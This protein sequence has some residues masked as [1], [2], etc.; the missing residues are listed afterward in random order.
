[1]RSRQNV[2]VDGSLRDGAWFATVFTDI[3]TRF[4][5]YKIAIFV[6][7]APEAVVRQRVKQRAAA[8]G[9]TVAEATLVSSLRSVASSLEVL[10]P[11]CDFVARISNERCPELKAYE[12]VDHSGNWAVIKAQFAAQFP[13]PG[14]F[15]E[16]LAPLS[17]RSVNLSHT[18]A[19]PLLRVK[20]PRLLSAW[21]HARLL[22]AD[23][24]PAALVEASKGRRG[25]SHLE[26]LTTA[27]AS[28][29]LVLSPAHPV[30][31]DPVSRDAAGIPP[32][33]VSFVFCYP[34]V[35]VDW[36]VVRASRI[37]VS[38]PIARVLVAG[39][40]VYFDRAGSI[41][42]V[43]AVMDIGYTDEEEGEE[44]GGGGGEGGVGEGGVDE[45]VGAEGHT[46]EHKGVESKSAAAAEAEAEAGAAAAAPTA[47]CTAGAGAGAGGCAGVGGCAGGGCGACGA[48]GVVGKESKPRCGTRSMLQ[49]EVPRP[50]P[51]AATEFLIA[52]KRFRPVT[53]AALL[54]KGAQFFAWIKPGEVLP[55]MGHGMS[56][57]MSAD[58]EHGTPTLSPLA[59]TSIGAG[60]APAAYGA[61]AYLFHDLEAPAS[62]QDCYFPV[63]ASV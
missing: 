10:T 17:L 57:S 56:G 11:L 14:E 31:L 28:T 40:F 50:L 23:V 34:A 29:R 44:Y 8:T 3:R 32:D 60:P 9:R 49:F 39:G 1:M 7:S 19:H 6:I 55:G 51:A 21:D 59:P 38:H 52:N 25:G 37:N 27:L 54:H 63:M 12:T 61:F 48:G 46:S 4:P 2:W 45:G 47:G 30:N 24:V 15:P 33:A 18:A 41:C 43:N 35:H 16:G 5:H 58:T 62:E 20:T 26:A 53:L 42:G 36:G 22:H 13:T